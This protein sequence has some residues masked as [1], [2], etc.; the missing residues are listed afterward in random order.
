MT[1][2]VK[3]MKPWACGCLCVFPCQCHGITT[4][5]PSSC[6]CR[7]LLSSPPTCSPATNCRRGQSGP[8]VPV[9]YQTGCWSV[10]SVSTSSFI[11][12][13]VIRELRDSC[14]RSR[15][16]D[17]IR[18]VLRNPFNTDC[19]VSPA[20]DFFSCK[21]KEEHSAII[22][23]QTQNHSFLGEK[24]SYQGSGAANNCLNVTTLRISFPK[25]TPIMLL[26]LW[27]NLARGPQL[28]EM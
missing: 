19:F 16:L 12:S 27:D 5:G 26:L 15:I 24:W 3:L 4:G 18:R 9:V 8:P 28:S 2:L 7:V 1:F 11:C 20:D 25:R 6:A 21:H 13:Y 22:T 10:N 14:T 17:W 23:G